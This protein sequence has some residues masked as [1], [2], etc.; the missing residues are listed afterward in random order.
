MAL[1]TNGRAIFNSYPGGFP[2]PGKTIIY[3][4]KSTIDLDLV[5]L[6]GGVL[7]KTLE[8]SIDPYLRT[9]MSQPTMGYK[10][11][12][13][14]YGPG[15]AVVLRSENEK[16]KVGDKF[17]ISM[18]P[19]QQYSVLKEEQLGDLNILK[20]PYNLPW[21]TFIGILGMPG[22]TAYE[23][24]RY[25]SKAKKGEILFV[26]SGAGPIG[27]LVIQ[28][29]KLDGLKVIASAG[30]DEKIK[31]MDSLGADVTFNYKTTNTAEVLAKEGPVDIYWDNVGGETLD[32]ASANANICARV[33]ACGMI[34]GYNN[35][36]ATPLRN[37]WQ[38]VARQIHIFG[39]HVSNQ[40]PNEFYEFLEPEIAKGDIKYAEDRFLGLENVGEAMSRVQR[41]LIKAKAVV[42]VAD[43][44]H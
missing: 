31:F 1:I 24:W 27:S 20:N 7:V 22:L 2:E 14:T 41:G 36:H 11:G 3:D 32:T 9:L 17:R 34:S 44:A 39:F 5:S 38:V 12:R 19:H 4:G 37:I 30:S 6:N 40:Y 28:L 35:N 15:I 23:G 10:I 25:Y 21:S 43:E 8:L 16:L 26:S 13:P 42:H 29:A 33:I 18:M